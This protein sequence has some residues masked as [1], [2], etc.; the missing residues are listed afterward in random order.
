MNE[1]KMGGP[2]PPG[3]YCLESSHEPSKCPPGSYNNKP[4][5]ESLIGC[6]LC[7]PGHCCP[8]YGTTEPLT[9]TE[10]YFC[11]GNQSSCEPLD[12]KCQ[13]GHFCPPASSN[14]F[15]C[16][17]GEYQ[18]EQLASSCKPCPPGYFCD[19]TDSSIVP[20]N[21]SFC[22]EGY[23]CPSR[24]KTPFACPAGT[25]NNLMQQKNDSDCQ[26]CKMP[27]YFNA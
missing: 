17:S 11:P 4:L 3:S 18:D 13:P 16:P 27:F 26:K 21:R 5:V 12:F 20:N 23:Y 2:C 24:T 14:Q 10:G 7:P 6:D 25:F 1:S 9:C 19:N 8:E 22:P 15:R